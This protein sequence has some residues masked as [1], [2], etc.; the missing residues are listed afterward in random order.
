M[1]LTVADV[2]KLHQLYPDHRIELDNGTITI[3][4]P[5]DFVAGAVG[6]EFSAQLRNWVKP[7]RLG[8]IADASAGYQPPDEGLTAPDVSFVSRDRLRQAPRSYAPVGAQSG[9]RNQIDHRPP[10]SAG[11]QTGALP[12][13]WSRSSH[14]G[15]SRPANAH[16]FASRPQPANAAQRRSAHPA[17]TVAGLG[18]RSQL[19]VAG[20]PGLGFQEHPRCLGT[21]GVQ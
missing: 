15:R 20:R 5:S 18:A 13:P 4:S 19:P 2:E 1:G 16:H 21:C 11:G 8:F 9:D 3:V 7:R 6:A 12:C 10:Q 17:A 14:P